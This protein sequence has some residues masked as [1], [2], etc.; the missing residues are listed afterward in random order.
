MASLIV[1][2]KT[3][4]NR[5]EE[6]TSI[7][8]VLYEAKVNFYKYQQAEDDS[9]ADYMHNFKDLIINIEYHGGDI[10]YDKDMMEH[11]MTIDLK[12]KV[13]GVASE[14]YMPRIIE[15]TKAVAFLKSANKKVYGKLLS[16]IRVQHSFKIDVY[17]KSLVD[18]YETLSSHTVHSSSTGS[19]KQR[20]ESKQ[21]NNNNTEQSTSRSNN[22]NLVQ[23]DNTGTS[24]LQTEIIPGTDGRT[25][26]HITCY[27]CGKRGHYADNC[28]ATS[29]TPS[30]EQQ[31]AN[32][33]NHNT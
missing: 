31:H 11:E 10:F 24:Y 22:S 19:N 18:A 6:N 26:E 25:I 1:E 20:K 32:I 14:D 27:N 2:I 4:S 28:P 29:N 5:I 16:D 13:P 15:K 30:N 12:N 3:L 8:D 33:S 21:P 7:Y 17:P 23:R 9:L